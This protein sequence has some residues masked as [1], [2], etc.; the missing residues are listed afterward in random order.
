MNSPINSPINTAIHPS[1]HTAIDA[2]IDA[3]EKR[4]GVYA[5]VCGKCVKIGYEQ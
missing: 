5:S 4:N 3:L 1:I 2:S